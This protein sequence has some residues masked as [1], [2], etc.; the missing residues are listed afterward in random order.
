LKRAAQTGPD[1]FLLKPFDERELAANIEIALARA[2]GGESLRR[3]LHGAI[4]LV[5]ALDEPAIIIDLEGR[6][7]HANGAAI[8]LFG[9]SDSSRLAR[10][11]LSRVLDLPRINASG[12]VASIEPLCRPDGRRYGSLVLFGAK[13]RRELRFLKSSATEANTTLIGYLPAPDAAGPGYRVGGFLEPCLAGSGDFFDIIPAGAGR[14]AFYGLDVMG[15][16]VIASLMVFS[17]RELLPVIAQEMSNA[18]VKRPAQVLHELYER[19]YRK[20]EGSKGTTFFT[21][22]YGT[23]DTATGEYIVARGG[24]TPVLHLE[25][26]GRMRVH[27]TKGAA[28]GVMPG[29]EV[30]E[31]YGTL[32]PGDRLLILSDGLL[33][34]FGGDGLLDENL[35]RLSAFADGLR[36]SCLEDFIAAFRDRLQ[37]TTTGRL[38]EDD[39]SLLV[40]EKL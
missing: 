4:S 29:A 7:A 36:A 32:S 10:T 35:E 15:H 13:E 25:A 26:G 30:E 23:I 24:H 28:V 38:I 21:I 1:G 39:A 6:V 34:V 40:I 16:G 5:D 22:A 3:E 9:V 11:E 20:G 37:G 27:Y 12:T 31:A 2:K 14:T 19:Y 33:A 18:E 17:L 8:A